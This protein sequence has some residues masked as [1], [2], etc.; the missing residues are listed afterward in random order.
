MNCDSRARP[1][2][3]CH[4]YGVLAS[5]ALND[6]PWTHMWYDIDGLRQY[7]WL[8]DPPQQTVRKPRVLTIGPK[9]A[10]WT[11]CSV[12]PGWI[13]WGHL[14][15]GGFISRGQWQVSGGVSGW[16][17]VPIVLSMQHVRRVIAIDRWHL[18]SFVSRIEFPKHDI[19]RSKRQVLFVS[20]MYMCV[21]ISV[22]LQYTY[23]PDNAHKD[24]PPIHGVS[25]D[26]Q[27]NNPMNN[28]CTYTHLHWY[29]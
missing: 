28:A 6:T 8:E 21:V 22:V 10:S 24:V 7:R 9:L 19:D 1:P 14:G 12:T 27:C 3:Q 29:T 26:V 20:C 11:V 18:A 17:D 13:S 15:S 16:S 25:E 23:S 4:G 2:K 5:R